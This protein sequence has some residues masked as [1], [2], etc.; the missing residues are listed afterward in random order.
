[1]TSAKTQIPKWWPEAVRASLSEALNEPGPSNATNRRFNRM[2]TDAKYETRMRFLVAKLI[3]ADRASDLEVSGNR[4][5]GFIYEAARAP[6]LWANMK[7]MSPRAIRRDAA[8]V[9]RSA[10]RFRR[11]LQ[12]HRDLITAAMVGLGSGKSWGDLNVLVQQVQSLEECDNYDL[13]RGLLWP[14]G[15]LVLASVSAPFKWNSAGAE[16]IFCIHHLALTWE[17]AFNRGPSN[18]AVANAVTCA[19]DLSMDAVTPERVKEL[20]KYRSRKRAEIDPRIV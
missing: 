18:K 11:I 7:R 2:L 14:Q 8:E 1:M 4:V 19:L 10:A 17:I 12:K 3:K 9:R 20:L 16:Q 5:I 6:E 13:A 15:A